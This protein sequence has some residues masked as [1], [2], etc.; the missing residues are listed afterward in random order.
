[1]EVQGGR[2]KERRGGGRKKGKTEW[3]KLLPPRLPTHSPTLSFAF[4]VLLP[5]PRDA[6]L[7]FLV[8]SKEGGGRMGASKSR[9]GGG[10][11]G[12]VLIA[13]SGAQEGR[14]AIE[15]SFQAAANGGGGGGRKSQV[16]GT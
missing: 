11:K 16:I 9:R 3:K 13:L 10:G 8:K 14:K 1:M 5:L 7:L 4:P 15:D 2:E 6:T 12:E